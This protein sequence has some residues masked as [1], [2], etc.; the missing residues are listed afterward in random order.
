MLR[1]FLIFI[2][3]VLSFYSKAQNKI[4]ILGWE[5]E[6]QEKC[7]PNYRAHAFHTDDEVHLKFFTTNHKIS[8]PG[9]SLVAD[10]KFDKRSCFEKAKEKGANLKSEMIHYRIDFTPPTVKN[11]TFKFFF[12]LEHSTKKIINSE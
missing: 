11:D 9:D 1:F 5:G 10:I 6:Y 3:S 8:T 4:L 7:N 2:I 12:I